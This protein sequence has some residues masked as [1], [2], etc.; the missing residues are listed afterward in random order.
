[1]ASSPVKFYLVDTQA[2]FDA[3]V[4]YNE[5]GLYFVMDTQRFYKGDK[6]MGVGKECSEEY[7]GLLSKED[8]AAL[9]QILGY[10]VVSDLQAVAPEDVHKHIPTVGAVL[11]ALDEVSGGAELVP[12]ATTEVAGKVKASEEVLVA[13][14]GTMSIGIIAQSKIANLEEVL[15]NMY[16]K[17]EVDELISAGVSG[18]VVARVDALEDSITWSEI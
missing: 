2:K 3:I 8:Y 4:S 7:S 14:D 18:D 17:S 12:I 15:A 16:T 5:F 13:T 11:A 10:S 9:R 6:L 1:M